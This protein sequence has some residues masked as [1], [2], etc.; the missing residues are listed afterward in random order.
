MSFSSLGI[1]ASAL[2][3]AQRAVEVAA[4]NVANSGTAG[5]TRQRLEVST[6]T[7]T[8]GTAGMRGDG[9]RGT[10]V[11]VLSVERLRDR[12]ADV[13]FRSEASIT[14]AATARSSALDRAES[15]LGP[16]AEG[17][18]E[19]L[20]RFFAA[21]DQLSLTPQ[22]PATRASVLA[23][24]AD[25]AA[26]LRSSAEELDAVVGEVTQRIDDQTQEADGLLGLVATLNQTIADATSSGQN[27]ND[28]YDQRDNALDRLSQLLGTR[29]VPGD[30]QTVEVWLGDTRLVSRGTSEGLA[31]GAGPTLTTATGAPLSPRG[32]V[33]GYLSVV[34]VDLPSYRSQLDALALGLRDAVNAIH[35]QGFDRNGAAGGDFFSAT[36]AGD[37]DLRAG[38]TGD[39]VAASATGAA[40]DGNGA[41]AMAR[42][43]TTAA[44]GGAT[45]GDAARAFAGRVGQAASD[46]ARSARAAELGLGSAAQTRA[47]LNGVNVDE[48][49]VDLVRYQHSYEAAAKV[50]AIVDEMLDTLINRMGR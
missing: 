13:A 43:R 19:A 44:V 6:S 12:L 4:H 40:A 22:D 2:Q 11:T 45:V 47:S 34:K 7:P 31:M 20:S 37:L 36:S 35:Q 17:T 25:L 5:F 38:L 23:A 14:G 24:G 27:P 10:G 1:G 29:V 18:P 39:E 50:I 21:W 49:M 9:Q 28:L 15:V 48:E 30:D 3:A 42:L 46:A 26:G 16:Y 8:P 32:E 33:G 41:I